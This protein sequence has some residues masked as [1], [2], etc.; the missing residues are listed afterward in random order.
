MIELFLR[1]LFHLSVELLKDLKR[2]VKQGKLV[3]LQR[4]ESVDE[5]LLA[6]FLLSFVQLFA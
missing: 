3:Y 1:S 4:N 2:E 5:V 6:L